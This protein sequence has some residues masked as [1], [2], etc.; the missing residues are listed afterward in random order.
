MNLRRGFVD[1][2]GAEPMEPFK[3]LRRRITV[4]SY[5]IKLCLF[6]I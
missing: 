4:S 3:V 5:G 6:S 1:P 2:E